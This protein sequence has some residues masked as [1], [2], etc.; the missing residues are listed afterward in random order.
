MQDVRKAILEDLTRRGKEAGLK[1]FEQ[2]RGFSLWNTL[3]AR[4][5]LKWLIQ[6][7]SEEKYLLFWR[8]FHDYSGFKSLKHRNVDG[9]LK[10][11]CIVSN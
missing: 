5:L 11:C 8:V 7:K 2:V 6:T 4:L 3:S 10:H 9:I 1:G